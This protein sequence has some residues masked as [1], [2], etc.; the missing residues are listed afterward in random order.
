MQQ[1]MSNEKATQAVH[2]ARIAMR[3]HRDA[4]DQV[5]T[6]AE[7]HE[8]AREQLTEAVNAVETAYHILNAYACDHTPRTGDR[9][10]SDTIDRAIARS[11]SHDETVTLCR[12]DLTEADL[13]DLACEAEDSA[14]D[15]S[16]WW[17]TTDGGH[18]WRIGITA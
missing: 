1:R 3:E 2:A 16:D 12:A 10:M 15:G 17:G 13:V 6:W 9:T 18:E 5:L 14:I 8:D 4:I 7:L 11:I